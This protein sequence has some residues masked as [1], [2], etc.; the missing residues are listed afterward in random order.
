MYNFSK[1]SVLMWRAFLEQTK[2]KLLITFHKHSCNGGPPSFCPCAKKNILLN[3]PLFFYT[4]TWMN[5]QC[6]DNIELNHYA[7]PSSFVYRKVFVNPRAIDLYCAKYLSVPCWFELAIEE[8]SW[9]LSGKPAF[10]GVFISIPCVYSGL[11][12]VSCRD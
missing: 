1:K 3:S 5:H 7:L 11:W 2:T 10:S 8:N 4:C 6:C 12:F 9:R